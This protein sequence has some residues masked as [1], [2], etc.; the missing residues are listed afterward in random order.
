MPWQP[1][2]M[3][4]YVALALL[5]FV[6]LV[7]LGYVILVIVDRQALVLVRELVALELAHRSRG[8]HNNARSVMNTGARTHTCVRRATVP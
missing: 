3:A 8:W 1:Q 5:P 7:P 4:T 2:P 6:L